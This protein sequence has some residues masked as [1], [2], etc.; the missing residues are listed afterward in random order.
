MSINGVLED[1]PLADVLQFIHLGQ[2]TGTLYLW[3]SDVDRAEISFHLGRLVGAWTPGQA[4]LGEKLVGEGLLSQAQLDESLQHQRGDGAGRSIGQILLD[5]S[6]V[7]REDIHRLLTTQIK[8]TVFQLVTWRSGQFHFEV[9]ELSQL[10]DFAIEPDEL[11]DLDLNTQMLLLEATRIF[12][13][14]Q[15]QSLGRGLSTPPAPTSG[16]LRDRLSRAG[17]TGRGGARTVDEEPDTQR[18]GGPVLDLVRCQVVSSDSSLAGELRQ[19][20]PASRAR[21]VAISLREAGNKVPGEYGSPVVVLDLRS[22]SIESA[23][24][25]TL[26]RTRPA[27]PVVV[28]AIDQAT[29]DVAYRDGAVAVLMVSSSSHQVPLET[30]AH[31]CSNLVRVA[32]YPPPQGNF[33]YGRR[34]GYS[35]FRRVV[36]DVQSGL[37]SATMALNLMHVISESVER[38]VLFLVQ[39]AQM[40]AVGA[41]GDSAAGESL[42]EVTRGMRLQPSNASVLRRAVDERQPLAVDFAAADL[43]QEMA[44]LLGSPV[45]GQTVVFPV[46]GAERAISVIYTDNG[47]SDASIQDIR[48]LELATSQVGV[49]FENELLLREAGDRGFDEAVDDAIH[50]DELRLR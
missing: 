4:R 42:A 23:A 16:R 34:G 50:R 10:D 35:R 18:S 1:L 29:I 49:A 13:E 20:L 24:V 3:R 12:D 43:P 8:D 9:D 26:A 17:L 27:A 22:P 21:V 28:L 25:A 38:A 46:I 41:F 44:A 5:T 39:G 30:L 33:G 45:T 6:V 11:L 48:I 37:L 36:F 31:A 32:A 47:T 14:R 15:R 7:K 2:R 19:V 40:V